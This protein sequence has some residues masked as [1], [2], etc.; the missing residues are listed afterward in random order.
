M[1]GLIIDEPWIGLILLGKKSWEMRKTACHHR[2]RIALIRKGSGRIVG[3]ADVVDSLQSLDTTETYA[4]AEPQHR[5]P[6]G[7][8]ELAFKDGWRTPWVLANAHALDASV[9]YKHPSG[10][11]IWVNLD[12]EVQIVVEAQRCSAKFGSEAT[13]GCHLGAN[14]GNA[15]P[16][17]RQ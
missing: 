12:P 1:K 5:I 10:A 11:V 15:V 17:S 7:R 3:R 13:S 4:R 14:G 6:V 9:P 2:G 8:Q 16:H